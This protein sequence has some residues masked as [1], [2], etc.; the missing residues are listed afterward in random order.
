MTITLVNDRMQVQ[1]GAKGERATH[2]ATRGYEGRPRVGCGSLPDGVALA[3]QRGRGQCPT[4]A[5]SRCERGGVPGGSGGRAVIAMLRAR[6]SLEASCSH[7][8]F[9]Q[10]GGC[11]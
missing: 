4:A 8:P 3:S 5:G 10:R 6:D 11:S 9:G 2:H 1:Q 7:C